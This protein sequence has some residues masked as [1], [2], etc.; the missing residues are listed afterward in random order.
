MTEHLSEEE[1][2]RR[3]LLARLAVSVG[4]PTAIVLVF[5]LILA[6]ALLGIGPFSADAIMGGTANQRPASVVADEARPQGKANRQQAVENPR[7]ATD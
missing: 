3:R 4:I 6:G 7:G 1:R 5:A 2:A